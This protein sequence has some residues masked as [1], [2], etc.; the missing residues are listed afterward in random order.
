[1]ITQ[2]SIN[3]MTMY[4]SDLVD[5]LTDA[6]NGGASVSFLAPL[7]PEDAAAYWQKVAA[8]MHKG[9]RILLVALENERVIGSVQ[10]VLA[11]QPNAPHRAE[12]QKLLVHNQHRRKGIGRA[13]MLAIE[14]HARRI[15]R[16]LIVLDTASRA[17]E[18]LYEQ[19]GYTRLGIIPEF[20]LN[21]GGNPEGT[22]VFYKRLM[23]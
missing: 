20:A 10:L 4:Q 15:N 5:L 18:Q 7:K 17:A 21:T 11:T 1:M 13:L 19:V 6:V 12:V 9:E 22:T 3:D 14:E 16:W 2:L 8:D 23:I